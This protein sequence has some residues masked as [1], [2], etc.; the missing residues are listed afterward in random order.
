MLTMLNQRGAAYMAWA[1]WRLGL[2]PTAVSLVNLVLGL[3]ASVAVVAL[4]PVAASGSA[5]WWPIG[6]G[7]LVAW[8]VAYM[9]DCADGQLAR[10]TGTG[11][12]A[13]ARCDILIDVAVQASVVAAV[14]AVAVAYRPETPA[15]LVAVFAATWM[16]NLVTSILAKDAATQASLVTAD[17]LV[18]RLVKLVRDFSAAVIVIG[19]VIAFAPA[20]MLWAMIA[21]TAVNCVF[22]LLSIAAAARSSL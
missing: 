10:V 7:A 1:A 17:N 9:L 13:G 21:F 22:L 2:S 3:A 6:L 5:P 19:L 20:L 4:A 12:A 15:W 16:T 14:A 8:Q 11:S 18:V